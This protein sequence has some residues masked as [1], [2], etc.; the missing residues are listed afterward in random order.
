MNLATHLAAAATAFVASVGSLTLAVAPAWPTEDASR[1]WATT[2][3]AGPIVHLPRVT[4]TVPRAPA[5]AS[6]VAQ[7][8]LAAPASLTR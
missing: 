6:A 2:A 1:A 5:A 3:P 7:I 4:V 8:A